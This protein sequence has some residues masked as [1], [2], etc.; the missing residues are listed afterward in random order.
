MWSVA[1][2]TLEESKGTLDSDNIDYTDSLD[3]A[4]KAAGQM[5]LH[6]LPNTLEFPPLPQPVHDLLQAQKSSRED[7]YLLDALQIARITKDDCEI[8]LIREANRISSGAH[9][10]LMREL[11]RFADKRKAEKGS[12]RR[13]RSGKEGLAE[14]EVESEGDAEA[15]FVA[16]CRR[17]GWVKS[18]GSHGKSLNPVQHKRTFPFALPAQERALCITCG[19]ANLPVS[20]ADARCND[21]LFPSTSQTRQAGDTSFAPRQLQRGCCGTDSHDEADS[22]FHD[23]AFEPQVLLIDAGCEWK[24]YAS[25]ITRTIPVGNGGKF[26][27]K[28][29]EIYELVLRMQK[30]S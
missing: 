24:D 4:L 28:A 10:V 14:W 11:G 22:T 27:E 20:N 6:T 1:P 8:A 29:G 30:V 15:L 18:F 19:F 9:E 5:T 16:T 25:D 26:T 23:G 13:V 17:A 3:Q 21:R 7:S 2:P 12:E